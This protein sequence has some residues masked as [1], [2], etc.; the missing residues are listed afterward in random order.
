[1]IENKYLGILEASM[2]VGMVVGPSIGAALYKIFG[3]EW[4]FRAIGI[5]LLCS[6]FMM[7]LF[8]PKN[9]A[10]TEPKAE[11]LVD[12]M[13]T[14]TQGKVV[15]QTLKSAENKEQTGEIPG[16][17]KKNIRIVDVITNKIFMMSAISAFH[18]YFVY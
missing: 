4:T 13:M 8:I 12:S 17:P 10:Q 14:E 6:D 2:G 5:I 9:I 18:S 11:P 3:F 7:C 15:N 1:M 16:Q